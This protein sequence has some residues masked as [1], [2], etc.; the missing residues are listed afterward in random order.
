MIIAIY[1]VNIV[2]LIISSSIES[3]CCGLSIVLRYRKLYKQDEEPTVLEMELLFGS[4][5]IS[6][7]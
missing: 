3:S 4:E 5:K 1:K 6:F 2:K 7:N